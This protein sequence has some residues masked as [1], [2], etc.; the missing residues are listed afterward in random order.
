MKAKRNTAGLKHGAQR[1]R[2][3]A[4]EKLESGI[5]TLLKEGR[6]INFNSVAKASGVSKAWLYKEPE[7]KS[8]I[9]HLRA[10]QSGKKRQPVKASASEVSLKSMV[11]TLR[12]RIKKLE[13]ENRELRK[14]NEVAYG[15]VMRVRE[16]EKENERL[17][18]E[19]VR[20][21][22]AGKSPE[23]TASSDFVEQLRE[24]GVD[25][26]STLERLVSK[27]PRAI[28]ETAIESLREAAS[29]GNVRN[30]GGFLNKAIRDAWHPNEAYQEKSEMEE[31]NEWWRWAYPQGLVIASQRCDDGVLRVLT[32]D[33]DWVEFDV[34]KHRIT[35]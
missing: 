17:R 5:Q 34:V 6:A 13:T 11:G 33:E 3:E 22:Q 21:R 10:K 35:C 8:R 27:T 12:E 29:N 24:L 19:N 28:V 16:L 23:M 31:F 2:K 26:N 15:Q 30:P 32:R 4:F 7:V 14:Q 1:K 18:A 9:E 20:L 25:L